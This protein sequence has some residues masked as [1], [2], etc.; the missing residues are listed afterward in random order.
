MKED[1]M[2]DLDKLDTAEMLWFN[3]HGYWPDEIYEYGMDHG[4]TVKETVALIDVWIKL[5]E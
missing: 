2:V 1:A 5:I 4:L 3:E